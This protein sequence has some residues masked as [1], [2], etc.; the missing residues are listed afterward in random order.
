V[1]RIGGR[2]SVHRKASIMIALGLILV[3]LAVVVVAYVWFATRELP[4]MEIDWGVFT[5]ELTPFQLFVV[6]AATILVLSI[7][8]AMLLAG[9]RKQREKRA[10]IKHLRREVRAGDASRGDRPA[11]G[12]PAHPATEAPAGRDQTDAGT[13]ETYV[14]REVGSSAPT[15]PIQ[16]DRPEQS[17]PPPPRS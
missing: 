14:D 16:Q 15:Q 12:A 10:E 6:G 13:R 2:S 7:G 1:V 17:P 3:L 8:T 4:A 11:P 5:A 9:L